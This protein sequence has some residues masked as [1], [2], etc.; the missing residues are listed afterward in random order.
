[1]D[2]GTV[3]ARLLAGAYSRADLFAADVRLVFANSRLYNTNKRSRVRTATHTHTLI[4]I[5]AKSNSWRVGT[6]LLDD[7]ASVGAVRGAVDAIQRGADA[8]SPAA[9]PGCARTPHY[10][11]HAPPR[12]EQ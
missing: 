9:A 8:S 7:G 11:P 2:L 5:T 3:R 12:T 10:A 4:V 1:M 6:D